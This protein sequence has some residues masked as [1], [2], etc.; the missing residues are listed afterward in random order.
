MHRGEN[1][2]CACSECGQEMAS[3]KSLKVH[4]A[5]VHRG[6]RPYACSECDLAFVLAATLRQHV[7][8][9]HRGER[10]FTCAE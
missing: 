7:A 5:T 3:A 6:E 9:V 8:V 2:S 4:I 1:H 10:P